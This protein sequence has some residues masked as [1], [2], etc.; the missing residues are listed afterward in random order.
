M[1]LAIRTLH[2][3]GLALLSM[4]S[5]CSAT[6]EPGL[7]ML[8]AR[9][10][11]SGQSKEITERCTH[12]SPDDISE[13]SDT[14]SRLVLSMQRLARP[15]R[16]DGR[17]VYEP[18]DAQP[19]TFEGELALRSAESWSNWESGSSSKIELD[20]AWP[21]GTH[22]VPG[23]RQL[24]LAVSAAESSNDIGD[25]RASLAIDLP[26]TGAANSSF[27]SFNRVHDQ[28]VSSPYAD[29]AIPDAG[30]GRCKFVLALASDAA[31]QADAARVAAARASAVLP[32]N[33]RRPLLPF[34]G[35]DVHG[36]K[37]ERRPDGTFV[38]RADGRI[39]LHPSNFTQTRALHVVIW[40]SDPDD[41]SLPSGVTEPRTAP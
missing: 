12:C 26:V 10:E 2:L 20:G 19:L 41:T 37:V 16:H 3:A 32:A 13:S 17:V 34:W 28:P 4:V 31:P 33:T 7:V 18:V 21:R 40:S 5:A 36:M 22:A 8:H 9:V 29:C 38:A 25:L 27:D 23:E 30:Q 11:L 6:R 24:A 14:S 35:E 39:E 1:T 15:V